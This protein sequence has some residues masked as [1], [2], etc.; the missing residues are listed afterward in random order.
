MPVWAHDEVDDFMHH[1]FGAKARS[2]AIFCS[3]SLATAGGY[4]DTVFMI[5]PIGLKHAIFSE[6]VEDLYQDLFPDNAGIT[7]HRRHGPVLGHEYW[8]SIDDSAGIDSSSPFYGSDPS[9]DDQ[10]HALRNHL[11]DM[12]FQ[13]NLARA[14]RTRNEVMVVC[15]RYLAVDL[16]V[17]D[18]NRR[19]VI[20]SIFDTLNTL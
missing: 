12:G 10:V 6:D 5:F 19:D 8:E 15:D 17:H 18:F 14:L 9:V 1:K 11:P 16:R 4:G 13:D 3:P 2:Q 7:I 20:D